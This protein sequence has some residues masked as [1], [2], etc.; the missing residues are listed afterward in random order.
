M[1][2]QSIAQLKAEKIQAEYAERAEVNRGNAQEWLRK[3]FERFY[4]RA[5][6]KT[7][8]L[9]AVQSAEILLQLAEL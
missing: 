2:W 1:D 3:E 5:I 7:D 4:R 8:P 9:E 6:S